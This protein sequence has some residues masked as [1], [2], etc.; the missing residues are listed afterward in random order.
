MFDVAAVAHRHALRTRVS[1]HSALVALGLAMGGLFSA[2]VAAQTPVNITPPNLSGAVAGS[3]PGAV[4]VTPT[5]AS[6]YSIPLQVPPGTAGMVP[7]LALEYD[8]QSGGGMLGQGWRVSGQSTI[9]RCGKTVA[10]DGV[11]RPV[12]LDAQDAFC[13]DGQRLRVVEGSTTEYRTE[14][15]TFSKV[16]S[17]GGDTT[18]GP[19]QWTVRTKAGTILTFGGTADATVEAPG[20]SVILSWA[21]SKLQDR[22]GN[23]VS[24]HYTENSSTGEHYLS[25]IRYTGNDA[26]G[27]TPY[28]AINFVYSA[29]PD[30]WL[31]Y[32]IGSKLQR[33]Q[34]LDS[35]Q[36]AINTAADGSGGTTVRQWKLAYTQSATSA[37]SLV[38]SISH[39]DGAGTSCLPATT[40][41]WTTRDPANN[42]GNAPGGGNWGGPG[43]IPF[44]TV[45]GVPVGDQ[46]RSK[47]LPLDLNGDG[48]ADLLYSS[49]NG[50]WRTCLSTGSSFSCSDWSGPAA[51]SELAVVGDFNG[52]GKGDMLIPAAVGGGNVGTG[53]LCFSTGS[54]FSCGSVSHRGYDLT[55]NA[56]MAGDFNNDA[57]DDLIVIPDYAPSD[58][59]YLCLS[60]GTGF[61]P[62]T[63]YGNSWAF[64]QDATLPATVR[65]YRHVADFNGDGR[66]DVVPFIASTTTHG[67]ATV[68]FTTENGFDPNASARVSMQTGAMKPAQGYTNLADSNGDPY[69]P[70]AD[71]HAGSVVVSPSQSLTITCRFTGVTGSS[72]FACLT[73]NQPLTNTSLAYVRDINDYDG[74]GRLDVMA[75]GTVGQIR[76]DGAMDGDVSFP[77]GGTTGI[78]IHGDFNG[79]GLPD[80]LF[81]D[82][83]DFIWTM[84]LTGSGSYPDLL[85]QVTNGDG[86]V[87]QVQYKG[88]HDASVHTAGAAASY[89]QRNVTAGQAL[90]SL[91]KVDNAKG[92][93]LETAYSYSGLRTD[94]L[95]NASVGF[96][97]VTT[98][99]KV[100]GIT[101]VSTLSQSFPTTGMP[102][103][104]TATQANGTVLSLTDNVPDSFTTAG[105]AKYP[106][107]RTATVTRK[108]LNG[109]A[110][111]TV[112][113]TINSGGI[114]TFGNVTSSTATVT[115]AGET[116]TTTTT[117]TYDNLTTN[118]LIGLLRTSSVTK[119]AEQ[120][121]TST[122]PGT[123]ALTGCTSNSPTTVPTAATMT[124]TLANSGQ[125][126]A[127]S[128][129]YASPAGT[130][131]TGPVNCAANTTNCGTVTVTS[132]TS[133]GTYAGTLT[134]TPT[135]AGTAASAA[136]S[137]VVRSL[138][139]LTLGSCS[140]TTTTA[141]TAATM[142]CTLGNTGQ[143]DAASVA[144]A[145]PAN[146]TDAGPSTCTAGAT[147]CG[148]V[149]VTTGTAAG[150]YSGT[151]TA[152]PTPAGTAA[153]VSVNL[154]VLSGPSLTLTACSSTTPTTSPTRA[155]MSCALGNAGQT[156]ASSV[157]YA[158]PGGTTASGPASCAANTSNCGT[159]TVTT[160][161]AAGTYS[162]TLT[163]TPSPSGGAASASVN[164]TV[165]SSGTTV[166]ASPASL[167]FGTV[168]KG[169]FSTVKTITLSNT[170][171]APA[172]I[173]WTLSYT[174][175]S[176]S[177]GSYQ[178]G[179][180]GST[181][182]SGGT[183]TAGSSCTLAVK[184]YAACSGGGRPANLNFQG[185][186]FP[187]VTVGLTAS[188]STSG[189][190][191]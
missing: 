139:A 92:G 6:H 114:D 186:A 150:S 8:S 170:G 81:Y 16:E 80:S 179:G 140:S 135:P 67:Y 49:G 60:S 84:T 106:Y 79:D 185:A 160:G 154:T 176:G 163:A 127:L 20:K 141:P 111:P 177:I 169:T 63:T 159:V 77:G 129:T 120:T 96:Q 3:L 161:T 119:T 156:A 10:Q 44:S 32:V 86:H 52:D 115:A 147:N 13:L 152:T 123:L 164:L 98:L 72:G 69:E 101:T 23:Y 62:C 26:G 151:L 65:Q 74:D 97:S 15:D 136:V 124:C 149:T 168:A 38:Q 191:Q 155:T 9:T 24:Y 90:V 56:Y 125:T 70:Y 57:R 91:L 78:V 183:L 34:R 25:R 175:G 31:G 28:N 93:W 33:L 171:G 144:Y 85:S 83:R 5:G 82:D 99:D 12:S 148:T 181:C 153:S 45:N 95:R 59:V 42:T 167:A 116:F 76:P 27:L 64:Y 174:G 29:R 180:S 188:T 142:T 172:T 126:V 166:A 22:R 94:L 71:I 157:S 104:V 35:I 73:R 36:A 130:T 173:T 89:P 121:G 182:S 46:I 48:K 133:A 117:S 53:T 184:Y 7:S 54:A 110:L 113:T 137:L 51:S 21:L 30:P 37:R 68:H 66:P 19:T 134:A 143:T 40:F 43:V 128:V 58:Q 88:L 1:V 105:G 47:V 50:T 87:T 108:D 41:G 118:W 158:T 145:G 55:S 11:R 4:E 109:A 189:V 18:I 165:A 162:G 178:L 187:T 107:V 100:N 17:A 190:C 2:S 39:C 102:L 122:T 112:T 131:V 14:I 146:T 75:G 132:G 61:L 103:T 138:P